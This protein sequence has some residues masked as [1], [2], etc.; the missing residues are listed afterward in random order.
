MI[1]LLLLF[2]TSSCSIGSFVCLFICLFGHFFFFLVVYSFGCVFL[3]EL[4]VS[5][6]DTEMQGHRKLFIGT[7]AVKKTRFDLLAPVRLL[8]A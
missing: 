6:F 5:L 7:A 3:F 4:Y 1:C 2:C 8:Y